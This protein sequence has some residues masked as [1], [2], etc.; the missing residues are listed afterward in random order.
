[1]KTC[2]NCKAEFE[3]Y[4]I[5]IDCPYC[6][7]GDEEVEEEFGEGSHYRKCISCNGT[8]IDDF[9]QDNFCCEDCLEVYQDSQYPS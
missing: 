3:P 9:L 8:G 4:V 2:L 5:E 7:D 6:E 1:M